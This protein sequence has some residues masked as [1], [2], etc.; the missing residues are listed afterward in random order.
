MPHRY[1]VEPPA[2][3]SDLQNWPGILPFVLQK[4]L[5]GYAENLQIPGEDLHLC[6][7]GLL[8]LSGTSF[9]LE[10]ESCKISSLIEIGSHE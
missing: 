7:E 9:S 1:P 5:E 10:R 2:C 4:H 8:C 6:S 3:V